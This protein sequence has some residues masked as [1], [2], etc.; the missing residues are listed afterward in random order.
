VEGEAALEMERLML[1]S[2][3][4]INLFLQVLKKRDDGYHEIRTLMQ[5]VELYDELTLEKTARGISVTCDHPNCPSDQ[6][7]LAFQASALLLRERRFEGGLR[8]HIRKRIPISA[9]LG[10]GSSN[11]ATTLKGVNQLFDL[12]LSP[13][14]LHQAASGL[15]SDVPFFLSS[16]QA[17]AFGRGEDIRPLKLFRDY[18]LV[19]VCPRLEVSTAWAYR[20]LRISL[21]RERKG[22]NYSLLESKRGFF[23]ALPLFENDLEEVVAEKQPLVRQIKVILEDSGSVRSSMSGSGPTVYGLFDKKP[24]AQEAARKLSQGDDWQVFLTEPIPAST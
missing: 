20:N 16:G 18:W 5:A 8:I 19:L 3:A 22:V 24:H 15:G 9:G 6:R 7:N 4:K 14:E 2:P 11:A 13:A 23:D 1:K 12:R 17:L 10:G 21:T